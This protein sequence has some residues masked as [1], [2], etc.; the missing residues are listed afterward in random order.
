[1]DP[2]QQLTLS[3]AKFRADISIPRILLLPGSLVD[4]EMQVLRR[5][6]S[7][8]SAKQTLSYRLLANY[9]WGDSIRVLSKTVLRV[10]MSVSPVLHKPEPSYTLQS[11]PDSHFTVTVNSGDQSDFHP[12]KFFQALTFIGQQPVLS[13]TS[14]THM[15][16]EHIFDLRIGL[17]SGY[18]SS[19]ARVLRC[20]IRVAGPEM[21][22]TFTIR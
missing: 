21:P 5:S 19:E 9:L 16:D 11:G 1:M 22:L 12:G 20:V 2:G 17:G 15:G 4:R 3:M 10:D 6:N 7:H 18:S 8:S 14:W 13:P